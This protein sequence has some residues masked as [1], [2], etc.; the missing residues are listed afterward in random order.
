MK[1]PTVGL[2]T[3]ATLLLNVLE[4]SHLSGFSN[5][6]NVAKVH[7]TSKRRDFVKV[8]YICCFFFFFKKKSN[9]I[10]CV[11]IHKYKT[12][13]NELNKQFHFSYSNMYNSHQTNTTILLLFRLV[14]LQQGV[15]CGCCRVEQRGKQVHPPVRAV[16][17]VADADGGVHEQVP[18]EARVRTLRCR[19]L[20]GTP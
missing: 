1:S 4:Q 15:A 20:R 10:S 11:T 19:R 6:A 18:G 8:K 7:S 13:L 3:L 17:V 16:G 9:S 5:F 2:A 14:V 12:N